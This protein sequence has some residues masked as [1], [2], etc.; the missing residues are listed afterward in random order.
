VKLSQIAAAVAEVQ[1]NHS[2][3]IYGPPKSGKTRLA[4]TAAKIEEIKNIYW[5][6]TENGAQTLTNMGLTEA[7]MDKITLFRI[8]DTRETPYAIETVLK[9]FSAKA[10]IQ[11]CDTHGRVACDECSKARA[12]FTP[13][14]LRNCTH[15]D[16]I[17]VDSGSQLGDSA[18]NAACAGK[19]LEFKPGWD[20]YGLQGKYLSDILS[21]VQQAHYTN[22]VFLTHEIALEDDQK[23]DRIF[24]LMGSKNFCMKVSKYFGTVAYVHMKLGKHA[25]GSSSTYRSDTLTG[26]R[27]N[28]VLEA[29]KEPTMRQILVD[30]GILRASPTPASQEQKPAEKPAIAASSVL[31]RLKKA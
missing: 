29:A 15:D 26:S 2:I 30:G 3:L 6:D 19:S 1:P 28:A 4:G 17:V 7:E 18:L 8:T 14:S 5:F 27:V 20:E 16:L 10:T 24:P 22:F 11:I 9:A 25:A 31:S 23:K 12:P 21:V 13:F